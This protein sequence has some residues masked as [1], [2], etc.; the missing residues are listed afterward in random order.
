MIGVLDM[1][2]MQ[3]GCYYFT[4]EEV[5]QIRTWIEEKIEFFKALKFNIRKSVCGM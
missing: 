2:T 4:Q 1:Y 5:K 3:T